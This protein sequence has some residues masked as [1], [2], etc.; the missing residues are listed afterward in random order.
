M[1]KYPD[2]KIGDVNLDANGALQTTP[3]PAATAKEPGTVVSVVATA[4]G[5][6]ILAANAARV[7][8]IIYNKD[9]AKTIWLSFGGVP[10]AG[11]GAPILPGGH[12]EIGPEYTGVVKGI[13]TATTADAAVV[14]I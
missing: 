10:V 1:P 7:Q 6:T 4:G 2:G 5:T 11:T 13:T 14:E 12:I 3:R 8:A 9:A